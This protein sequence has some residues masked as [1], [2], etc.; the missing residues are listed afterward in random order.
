L[1]RVNS[2]K[3][4]KFRKWATQVLKEYIVNGYAINSEKIT[5]DRFLH[6]E[7]DMN[8]LKHKVDKIDNLIDT[9]SLELKQGIFY[10][11]QIFDAYVFVNDLLKSA[12]KKRLF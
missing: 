1:D 11:G 2:I 7:N 12:K 3:A 9:N 10:D 6:L 5:I 8:T 4:T